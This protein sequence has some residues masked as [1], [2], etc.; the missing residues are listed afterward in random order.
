MLPARTAVLYLAI[1]FGAGGSLMCF[2]CK[3]FSGV[4]STV[5]SFADSTKLFPDLLVMPAGARGVKRA[6]RVFAGVSELSKHAPGIACHPCQETRSRGT[7]PCR[8]GPDP[9]ATE[10][11]RARPVYRAREDARPGQ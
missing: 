3:R 11:S 8:C 4:D 7:R 9:G 6:A 2:S 10:I 5:V 1:G